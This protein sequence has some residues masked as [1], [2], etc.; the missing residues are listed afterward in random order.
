MFLFHSFRH[1][2]L[3]SIQYLNRLPMAT[4]DLVFHGK[5]FPVP[6]KYVF[7]LFEHHQVML[8]AKSYAVQSSVP[9][10]VFETF[11]DSLKTQIKIAVTKENAISLSLL[12]TEFFLPELAAECAPFPRSAAKSG[13][14]VSA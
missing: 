12:A 14:T 2:N 1:P 5:A 8:D 3:T 10:D 11:A 4:L 9:F 13:L 7:E 6:K